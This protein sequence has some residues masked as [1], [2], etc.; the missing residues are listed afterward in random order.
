MIT[1]TTAKKRMR[2]EIQRQPIVRVTA[3]PRRGLMFLVKQSNG[4]GDY[5][6]RS[7]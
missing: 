2:Q 1:S 4:E 6:G 5:I 7:P 3:A